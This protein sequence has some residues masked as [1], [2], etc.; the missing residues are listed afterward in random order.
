MGKNNPH[1]RGGKRISQ[2]YIYIYNPTHPRARGGCVP[3]HQLIWE[4]VHGILIPDGFV[5]HHLDNNRA[6]NKKENLKLMTK[7]NHFEYH[8]GRKPLNDDSHT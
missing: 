7:K 3:E 8:I 6:N 4:R 1:W 5:I 2:G